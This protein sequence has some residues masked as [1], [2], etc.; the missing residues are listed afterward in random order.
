MVVPKLVTRTKRRIGE[1]VVDEVGER[2][3]SRL[4]SMHHEKGR[5]VRIVWLHEV[6]LFPALDCRGIEHAAKSAPA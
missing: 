1:Q 3:R 2:H 4:Q 5:A 6:E